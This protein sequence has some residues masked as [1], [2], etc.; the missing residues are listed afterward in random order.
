M[1]FHDGGFMLTRWGSDL[2]KISRLTTRNSYF[3]LNDLNATNLKW[4][5]RIYNSKLDNQSGSY[6]YVA[7]KIQT[8]F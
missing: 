8:N 7:M 5:N 3:K 1:I 4:T 2:E 6:N